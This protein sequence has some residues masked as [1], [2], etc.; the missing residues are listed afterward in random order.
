MAATGQPLARE[1]ILNETGEHAGLP[2]MTDDHIQK[3]A[4]KRIKLGRKKG[5]DLV[6]HHPE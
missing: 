1:C 6:L 4:L 2:E 3:T 5:L